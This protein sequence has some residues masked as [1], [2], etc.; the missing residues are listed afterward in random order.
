MQDQDRLI[1]RLI[2]TITPTRPFYRTGPDHEEK[3]GLRAEHILVD[4]EKRYVVPTRSDKG[5]QRRAFELEMNPSVLFQDEKDMIWNRIGGI[6]KKKEQKPKISV[7][8]AVRENNPM[9]DLFGAF[10]YN[11]RIDIGDI[12]SDAP[13]P[14]KPIYQSGCRGNPIEDDHDFILQNFDE[15]E[16]YQKKKNIS[17][18]NKIIKAFTPTVMKNAT[19]CKAEWE[20]HFPDIPFEGTDAAK[21]YIEALTV[22]GVNHHIRQPLHDHEDIPIGTIM[23]QD[24]KFDKVYKYMFGLWI[25]AIERKIIFDPRQGGKRNMGRGG[26]FTRDYEVKLLD[27]RKWQDKGMIKFKPYQ[28]MDIESDFAQECIAAWQSFDKSKIDFSC[29]KTSKTDENGEE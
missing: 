6:V 2:G 8:T 10:S 20:K 5:W 15:D 28:E 16:Y 26:C 18:N 21:K 14:E 7:F 19:K 23:K 9:I 29:P 27:G 3:F 11:G 13:M 1:I 4:G 22:D 12:I 24:I 17:S 25:C